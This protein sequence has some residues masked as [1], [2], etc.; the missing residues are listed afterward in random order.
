MPKKTLLIVEDDSVMRET[1][2]EVFQKK[3]FSVHQSRTAQEG[4]DLFRTRKSDLLLLDLK[5]PDGDGLEVLKEVRVQDDLVPVIVMTAFSDVKTAIRAM[6]LG[7]F[8]YINKPFELEELALVVDRA[9]ETSGIKDDVVR[10]SRL[11]QPVFP[12]AQGLGVSAKAKELES[13]VKEVA[14]ASRTTVLITGESGTGKELVADMIHYTSDRSKAPFLKVN[15]SAIPTPLLE[16]EFFG[17]EKGAFTDAK[18]TKKGLLELADGGALFLDEI[19][20]MPLPLQAKL[21]RV[22]E[23]QTFK[24]VGGTRDIEVDVRII[25]ST[26]RDLSEMIREKQFRDDLFYRLKVF[27]I[28]VPPLRERREDI[29]WLIERFLETFAHQFG[30]PLSIS[31][32]A[33][34]ILVGYHW[35]GNIRELKNVAERASILTGDGRIEPAHLPSELKTTAHD[36]GGISAQMTHLS[37]EEV[38]KNHILAVLE[39]TLGNKSE[40]SRLL[41]ISRPTLREKLMQYSLSSEKTPSE[42]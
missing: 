39:K 34:E 32:E 35:P 24:R 1:L 22:L 15:C 29:P 3:G 17:F 6:K 5:L 38:E 37:L 10:L 13:T 19:S 30:K 33:K 26:N 40:A 25:A 2:A 21:L 8:D 9:L 4:L 28:L 18:E 14:R 27:Q 12:L 36:T 16:A 20:E 11:R 41:G 42:D 31:K 23:Y 7:A